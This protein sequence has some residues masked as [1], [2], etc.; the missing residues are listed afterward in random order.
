[1]TNFQLYNNNDSIFL[2]LR[3]FDFILVKQLNTLTIKPIKLLVKAFGSRKATP[4]DH[5]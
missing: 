4:L 2:E 1:M 5:K 3:K